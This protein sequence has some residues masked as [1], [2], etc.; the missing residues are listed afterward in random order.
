MFISLPCHFREFVSSSNRPH[1]RR[2]RVTMPAQDLHIRVLHMWDRLRNLPPGQLMKLWDCNL[3]FVGLWQCYVWATDNEHN[4]ILSMSIW[5]HSNTFTGSWGPL[6][7]CSCHLFTQCLAAEHDPVL[8]WPTYTPD[9][10]P[11]EQF[12]MLWIDVY[13]S[14]FQFPPILSNFAQPSKRSGTTFHRPQSTACSTL[15][16]GDVL[17]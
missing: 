3:A 1:N 9:M 7:C 17:H 14:M 5:M 4:C 10:S 16:E 11:I 13:N 2:P 8:P 15:C 6:S 12:G